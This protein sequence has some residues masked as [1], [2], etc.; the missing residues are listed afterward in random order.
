VLEFAKCFVNS[1]P[2]GVFPE[3]SGQRRVLGSAEDPA[4]V[5]TAAITTGMAPADLRAAT[6]TI[7][8]VQEG[9]APIYEDG[10]TLPIGA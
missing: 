7:K 9:P 4:Y 3:K 1:C 10:L 8:S 2:I 6:F 5:D